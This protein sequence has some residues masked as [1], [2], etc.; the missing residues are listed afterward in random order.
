M[1]VNLVCKPE[2][3]L[4]FQSLFSQ[5]NKNCKLL[6]FL[7]E[8]EIP[9]R[10]EYMCGIRFKSDI[11]NIADPSNMLKDDKGMTVFCSAENS[12]GYKTYCF[13]LFINFKI[14]YI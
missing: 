14:L 9:G 12:E 3:R 1:N 4:Y 7:L 13:Y 2:N 11:K 5:L 6:G 8:V 10:R